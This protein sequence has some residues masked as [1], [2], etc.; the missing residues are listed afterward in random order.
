VQSFP[1]VVLYICLAAVFLY[2]MARVFLLARSS[3]KL[4][5][6]PEERPAKAAGAA[7]RFNFRVHNALVAILHT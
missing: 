2:F 5:Q 4:P 7:F 6:E 1:P 3:G